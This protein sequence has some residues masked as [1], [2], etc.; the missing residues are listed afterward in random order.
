MDM[1]GVLKRIE[2]T[3]DKDPAVRL[4]ETKERYKQILDKEKQLLLR[5]DVRTVVNEF[6]R[7]VPEYNLSDT[8]ALDYCLWIM[9]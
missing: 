6:K 5:P 4:K 2:Y 1:F 9:R 8:K 3:I 7:L